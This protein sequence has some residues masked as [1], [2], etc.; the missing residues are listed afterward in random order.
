MD[1]EYRKAKITWL[2]DMAKVI[3]SI[4]Q[5]NEPC[6]GGWED[7][8]EEERQAE[9]YKA[10]SLYFDLNDLCDTLEK[11]SKYSNMILEK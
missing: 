7:A 9:F 2:N 6:E 3:R 1:I 5:K 4:I 11:M 10:S 8:S